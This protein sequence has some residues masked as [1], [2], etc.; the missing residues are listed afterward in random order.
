MGESDYLNRALECLEMAKRAK[1][2]IERDRLVAIAHEW[3]QL[4]EIVAGVSPNDAA[5]RL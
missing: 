3:Q 2:E 1:T 5:H 4:A